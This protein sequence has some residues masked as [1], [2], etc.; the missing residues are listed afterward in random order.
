MKDDIRDTPLMLAPAK[1]MVK[2]EPLGVVLIFGSWNYPYVVNLKPLC[3][4]ITTGNC[5]V[6]K[7]SEM[8]PASST[9]IKQLVERYLD[10]ECFSVIEGGPEVAAKI[11][12]YPWDLIC[13]TGSTMKG[14]LVAEAAAKNLV[15]C[16]LELGGKCP[17]VVDETADLDFAASKVVFA[18]FNNSG[19]TCLATDYVM[20]HEAVKQRFLDRMQH[21][22]KVMYGGY[23]NGSPEMGKIVTDWHC[24]RLKALIESS[25]GKVIIGGKIDKKLKYVEPT[26]I[27]NP[28]L[29]APVMDE[30]I[31]GPVLPLLTFV[32]I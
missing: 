5:A 31:F 16:I 27:E 23:E 12:G 10:Q 2:Y 7:P 1:T 30:E 19:Q 3:Q 32:D 22:L 13:F 26:V 28:D 15:P 18:R 8:A 9:A 17:V 25:K 21:H 29:K 24:D 11:S 6:I 14:K 4:A 20:V